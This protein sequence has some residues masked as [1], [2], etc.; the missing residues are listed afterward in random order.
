[1]PEKME[2]D[3]ERGRNEILTQKGLLKIVNKASSY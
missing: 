1:M 3:Q 2:T